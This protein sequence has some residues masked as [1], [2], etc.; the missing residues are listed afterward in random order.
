MTRHR[1]ARQRGATLFVAM[2]ILAAL[3]LLAAWAFNSSTM[4]LRVVG[5]SQTRAEVFAAGQTAIEQTISSPAF[6]QQPLVVAA[7]PIPIDVDGDGVVDQTARLVPAPSCYRARTVRMNEL[8]AAQ[9]SDRP[10]LRSAS[11]ANLG[12]EAA[13][14][15]ASG[16]SLCADSEW[17]VR[18]AVNS[19]DSGAR[20]V[21]NQ[22]VAMRGA[23]TDAANNCP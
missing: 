15:E 16:D 17:N 23:I 20:A 18:A 9:A 12:I 4:N 21:V 10:C 2:I 5:N 19:P 1:P 8:D 13:G 6:M 22:G 14:G 11:S 7:A 3:A